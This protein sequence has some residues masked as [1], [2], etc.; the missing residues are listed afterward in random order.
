MG[1]M[2]CKLKQG[3]NVIVKV[4]KDK[5]KTGKILKIIK[6]DSKVIVE[7]INIVKKHKKSENQENKKAQIIEKEAAIHIS[8]VMY[9]SSQTKKGHRVQYDVSG[10]KKI[11][12]LSNT[13]EKIS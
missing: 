10:D 11:R 13:H 1:L 9:Y 4:G 8:N 3:D 2:K 6:A 12:V 7:G 5:G